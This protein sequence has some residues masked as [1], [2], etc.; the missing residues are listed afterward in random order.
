M[1]AQG[2]YVMVVGEGDKVAPLPI[3]TG[4]MS[5]D[6]WVVTRGLKT[7]MRVV[8]D[9]LQKARPGSQVRPVEVKQAP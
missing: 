9:G 4:P 5:Q 8:V 1:N 6:R 3:E 2:P 7:G